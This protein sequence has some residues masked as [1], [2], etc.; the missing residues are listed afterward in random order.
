MQEQKVTIKKS[1]IVIRQ[2]DTVYILNMHNLDHKLDDQM[3]FKSVLP[4]SFNE[5]H[6]AIDP[7]SYFTHSCRLS[8]DP[9]KEYKYN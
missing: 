8:V 4:Q 2:K 3:D 9:N 5:A 1:Y 7:I 6:K